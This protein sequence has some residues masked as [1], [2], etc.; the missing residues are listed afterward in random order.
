[1]AKVAAVA[2]GSIAFKNKPSGVYL[3]MVGGNDKL[4]AIKFAIP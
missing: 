1:V 3:L 4:G 2:A